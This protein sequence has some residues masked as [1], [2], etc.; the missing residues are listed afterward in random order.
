MEKNS[1]Y[2]ESSDEAIQEK[3]PWKENSDE[4]ILMKKILVKKIKFFS[5]YIKN[6]K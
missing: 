2:E 6:G 4:K 3:L 5:S 1:D